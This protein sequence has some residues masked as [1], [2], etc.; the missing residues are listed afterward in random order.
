MRTILQKAKAGRPADRV[1]EACRQ[2]KQ[3]VRGLRRKDR[4]GVVKG[5]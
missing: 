5:N 1:E 3:R 4:T 2:M